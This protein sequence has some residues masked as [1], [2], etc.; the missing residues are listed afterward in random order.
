[1]HIVVCAKQV[2]D[3]T[4]VRIDPKTNALVREGVPSIIN[5]Y[6]GIVKG[7]NE[8]SHDKNMNTIHH[9]VYLRRGCYWSKQSQRLF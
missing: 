7:I 8:S 5:P 2:P 9:R 1:L 4:E 6:D 3:T